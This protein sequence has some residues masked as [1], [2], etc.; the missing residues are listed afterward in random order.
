M[1]L[2][3]VENHLSQSTKTKQHFLIITISSTG[4]AAWC[5]G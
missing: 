4:V 1:T 5:S 3:E 2:Y